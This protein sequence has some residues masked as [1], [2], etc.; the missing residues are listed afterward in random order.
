MKKELIVQLHQRFEERVHKD[1]EQE[2]WLARELQELLGY[3][4][5]RNFEQVIEKAKIACTTAGVAASDHFAEVSK[6]VEL[7]SAAQREIDDYALTRYACYLIAQNGDPKK[8]EIAFAMTY[9]AVQTRRAE[10]IEQRLADWERVQAREKL[11]ASERELSGLIYERGVD[12][13]GFARIRSKGDSALFGGW[14]TQGMKDKLGVPARRPL[15]DF[16]PTVTIKAKDFAAEITNFQV[17]ERALRGEEA[18]AREHVKN[19]A[20][21]RKVLTDRGIVPER[22]PAAE[23]VK[24]V[25]RRMKSDEKKLPKQAPR[26][27]KPGDKAE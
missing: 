2:F 13:K 27:A 17:R 6:K 26:L 7:G 19:N 3:T 18:V 1:G 16:L 8:P 22:L 12:D 10:V 20:D 5:W 25:E 23:D 21:V 4:Q 9:F 11:T 24:K 14:S 15:A